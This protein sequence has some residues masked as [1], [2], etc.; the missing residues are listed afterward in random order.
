M[1]AD[2]KSRF[3]HGFVHHS[4]LNEPSDLRGEVTWLLAE[5]LEKD[6]FTRRYWARPVLRAYLTDSQ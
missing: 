4:C 6:R 5:A 1:N 3:N 2:K